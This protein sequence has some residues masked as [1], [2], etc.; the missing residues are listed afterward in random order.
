MNNL[1]T[2]IAGIFQFDVKTGNI[3]ANL[4]SVVD[5]IH[6]LSEKGTQVT[7]LPELWPCGFDK[8]G[9]LIEHAKRTP[10]I[11]ER[12]STLAKKHRMI[13]AGSLPEKS[14]NHLY[15]TMVVV[16][17]DGAV[18]GQYRKVHLF[19]FIDEDKAFAAG[20]QAVVCDTSYGPIG[21]MICYDL[22]FPEL[23]RSLAL[24]G[25]RIVIVSA[26]WPETRIDHWNTLLQARAIENQIFIVAS[27][28]VGQDG[29]LAFNGH[30][31][32]ISPDGVILTRIINHAS[33]ETVPI[34]LKEIDAIRNRFDCIKERKPD[35]YK[36]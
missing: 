19:S 33:E 12:L 24:A 11:I 4:A 18:A 14:G 22:R 17:K 1:E 9:M 2:I 6:R 26:Q 5:G 35:A 23:C 10:Q 30:S 7:V 21:L 20:N 16:D 25:A 3:D 15:N 32:I 13:I 27:N 8:P 36:I 34:N 31:Q 28:R 29:N